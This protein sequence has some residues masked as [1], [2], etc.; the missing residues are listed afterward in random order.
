MGAV[1]AW[2]GC[3]SRCCRA[4]WLTPS[5]GLSGSAALADARRRG[6]PQPGQRQGG[7]HPHRR[8]HAVP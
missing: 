5:A 2:L 8:H 6:E 4:A 1:L 7:W 3:I